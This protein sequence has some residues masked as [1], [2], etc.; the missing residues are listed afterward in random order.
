MSSVGIGIKFTL[1]EISSSSLPTWWENSY[2]PTLDIIKSFSIPREDVSLIH[3]SRSELSPSRVIA[4]DN[5][6]AQQAIK[7]NINGIKGHFNTPVMN[8]GAIKRN[9]NVHEFYSSDILLTN[10]F[11][12]EDPLFW[13]DEIP[14]AALDYP[15]AVLDEN[16]IPVSI[17]SYK[18]YTDYHPDSGNARGGI[19]AHALETAANKYY[20]LS[21]KSHRKKVTH[22]ALNQSSLF[23]VAGTADLGT[24]GSGLPSKGFAYSVSTSPGGFQF[25]LPSPTERVAIR[26]SDNLFI[27]ADLQQALLPTEPWHLAVTHSTLKAIDGTY[28]LPE[29]DSQSFIAGSPYLYNNNDY[30][31]VVNADTLHVSRRSPETSVNSQKIYIYGY[32]QNDSLVEGITNDT[33]KENQHVGT[34][35]STWVVDN[36]SVVQNKNLIVTNEILNSELAYSV[37]YPYQAKEYMFTRKD[38]NPW[39]QPSQRGRTVV[40]YLVPRTVDNTAQLRGLEYLTYDE[41]GIIVEYSQDGTLG[42]NPA[43]TLDNR[44]FKTPCLTCGT[45]YLNTLGISFVLGTS[46]LDEYCLGHGTGKYLV[47]GEFTLPERMDEH[48]ETIITDARR[49]VGIDDSTSLQ[50][51]VD[52][53]PLFYQKYSPQTVSLGKIELPV[54]GA[55]ISQSPWQTAQTDI[56]DK[57]RRIGPASFHMIAKDRFVPDLKVGAFSL[58]GTSLTLSWKS[59]PYKGTTPVGGYLKQGTHRGTMTSVGTMENLFFMTSTTLDLATGTH[60]YYHQIQAFY[61]D[62][63]SSTQAG[64]ISNMIAFSFNLEG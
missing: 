16:G 35:E 22:R 52:I 13:A 23:H 44:Y 31:Q 60:V 1:S 41:D 11:I 4:E 10:K 54:E 5:S 57:Y 18:V 62:T 63:A 21:F 33:S 64:G 39:R 36:L 50:E 32:D 2:Y 43:L 49:S 38:L 12:G 40:P 28:W 24:S 19:V 47:L 59:A 25:T 15:I 17:N 48:E 55:L 7:V 30:A 53:N 37:S 58:S 26:P 45:G 9:G 8:T 29:W 51:A 61:V 20:T 34:W 56:Q 14:L 6:E 42:G 27:R 3:V 46:F